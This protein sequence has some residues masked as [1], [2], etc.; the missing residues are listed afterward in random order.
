MKALLAASYQVGG[1]SEATKAF[2][3]KKRGAVAVQAHRLGL[4]TPRPRK[5]KAPGA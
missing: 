3:D 1:L 5:P 2:P 4:T